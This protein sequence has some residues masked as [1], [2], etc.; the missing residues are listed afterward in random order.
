MLKVM[1]SPHGDRSAG[2]RR[3]LYHKGGG[4]EVH[5]IVDPTTKRSL[6]GRDASEWLMID[7]ASET[8]IASPFCCARCSTVH[9]KRTGGKNDV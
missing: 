6:C 7:D 2:R 4:G 9:A 5:H 1:C 3:T 8:L